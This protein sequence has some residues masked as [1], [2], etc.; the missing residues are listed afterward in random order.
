MISR[1]G[2]QTKNEDGDLINRIFRDP[3]VKHG[4]KIF[5][6]HKIKKLKLAE[7]GDKIYITCTVTGKKR[8][9]KPEEIIRQLSVNTIIDD[10]HY[11]LSRINI[12]VPIKMGSA[13]A[14]KKADIVV[15]KEDTKQTPYII[16]EVKKPLR[17][18]GLEQLHSYMNAT[19]VYY[20]GWING[21]NAV[22]ELR[23]EPNLFEELQRLPAVNEGLDDV[24]TPIKKNQL[25]P[26]HDLKEEVQYLEDTVLANAGVSAFEEIFK[27]IFAKI[28]DEFNKANDEAMEFRTTT[29]A[30]HEQYKRLNGLF[31]KASAE[32][33]DIFSDSD[34][35]E[36]TPEALIAVASAFQTKK[37]YDADLDVIDAA[38]EYMINPEQKADKG[39]YFTP[40]PV[41]K[42]CVKMLNPKPEER[43]LDPACGPGG[44]LIH[45]LHWVFE[46]FLKPKYK[47]NLDKRKFDYANSRLFGIDFDP[48]LSR[49][50]K[51]M[52]LI[53]GDG[54][55]NVYRV[56]SLD[57][58]EWKNRTDGLVGAIQDG[59]FD[60]VMT[61]PP[62]A[63]K[64]SQPEILG[65]YDLAYKD[66]HTKNKRVNKLTRDVMF[67]ER[68][69]RFLKP[70]GRMAIVLPQG[71]LNN[72]NAKYIRAWVM[73]KARILAV[74]GLHVN[75]FKP[76]TGTKTSVLLLKKW[77]EGEEPIKDYPIFLAVN[78]KPVKDNSGDYIFRKNPDGTYTMDSKDKRIIDHDL[79]EIA[80]SF[81]MFAKD[82]SFEFW[83]A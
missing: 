54:R 10:L 45:S 55:S 15:Y 68:C 44:F 53:A 12:E 77:A 75:T 64:I 81:N 25:K 19:G 20:G 2:N 9:A 65:G 69:L 42:M 46:H 72:T 63:G 27:L 31:K 23:I 80:D 24:K 7:E 4:I 76:F 11:P 62:F 37:F 41:V 16:I 83:R 35:I 36:L 59:K 79:N 60:L 50:A 38:F 22:Y 8:L 13:Y 61:N 78:E 34:K 70:G 67:V 6:P 32:W 17:K 33:S 43:V 74:V 40:R 82:Q 47:N 14:S 1:P 51:A 39:Q 3:E 18:D 73:D 66:D 48:R 56:N 71:N 28:Y 26:I 30:P 29:A 58:R 21:N 52:M 49:V 5:E 57:P